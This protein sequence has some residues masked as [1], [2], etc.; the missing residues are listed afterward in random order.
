V[1]RRY[2][3]YALMALRSRPP[4]VREED[5]RLSPLG[6]A[7]IDMLVGRASTHHVDPNARRARGD[8]CPIYRGKRYL[9]WDLPDPAGQPSNKYGGSAT[10]STASSWV[11]LG[12]SS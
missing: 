9:N 4:S 10:R 6:H 3:D 1:E 8:A 2:T 5:A 12:R 7:D 11:C